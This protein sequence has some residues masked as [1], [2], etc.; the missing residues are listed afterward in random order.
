MA[1]KIGTQATEDEVPAGF[2]RWLH[3]TLR[4]L[5]A[6]AAILALVVWSLVQSWQIYR[7]QRGLVGRHANQPMIYTGTAYGGITRREPSGSSSFLQC[8]GC[9]IEVYESFVLVY[10]DKTKNSAALVDEQIE[11]IPRDAVLSMAFMP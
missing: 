7:L 6:V 11:Y 4:E 1:I 2:R 5:L 3:L 10:G 8:H 9:K